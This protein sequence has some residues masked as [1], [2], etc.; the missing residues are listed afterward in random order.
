VKASFE[1]Q[2]FTCHAEFSLRKFD[3][4]LPDID[5]LVIAEEPTLGFTMFVCEVKCPLPALWG[6]D[7]LRA[8][9]KDSVSKAFRQ[10]EAIGG[11]LRTDAGIEF[12]R[13]VV[14][15]GGLQHFDGF[16]VVL[17]HLI[18]TSDNAGMFFSHETTPIV[19]IRTLQRILECSDGDI[20][21]VLHCIAE[22]NSWADQCFDAA[23]L[24]VEVNGRRVEYEGVTP[25]KRLDFAQAIWRSGSERQQMIDDFVADGHHPF[26]CL[27][28]REDVLVARPKS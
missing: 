8:R 13:S 16:V 26:D 10:V 24:E 28:G 11:F 25:R 5:L 27:V 9:E 12:I 14:P 17:K 21:Y 7:Q 23:L 4:G 19:N 3:A 22:Y 1:A 20:L 6:K 18:V 2:G 15:S